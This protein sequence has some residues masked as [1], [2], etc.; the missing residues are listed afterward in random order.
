MKLKTIFIFILFFTFNC[1][2]ARD[3]TPVQI[4]R[5]QEILQQEE[6]LR[7]KIEQPQKVFIKEIILPQGCLIPKDELEQINRRFAGQWLSSKEIQEL[8]DILAKAYQ[9]AYRGSKPPRAACIIEEGKL[10][11]NFKEK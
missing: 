3:I 8:L 10:I 2:F 11:I 6:A 9:K 4:E 1:S 5:S 7:R